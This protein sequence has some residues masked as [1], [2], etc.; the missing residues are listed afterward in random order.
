[1]LT[2]ELLL[3][4]KMN[5]MR[6][7]VALLV[8][9]LY[10]STLIVIFPGILV[11]FH[12]QAS[13]MSLFEQVVAIITVSIASTVVG[14]GLLKFL[15]IPFTMYVLGISLVSSTITIWNYSHIKFNLSFDRKDIFPLLLLVITGYVFVP[16]YF[17]QLV[18]SG[19]DM[20]THAYIAK[21]IEL[22]NTFPKTYEPIVPID[23]FGFEP[24]GLP[25]L[26]AAVSLFSSL[27]IYKSALLIS[28]L[29]YPLAGLVCFFLLK[30]QFSVITAFL[31]T[32]G[33]FFVDQ[34]FTSYLGWGAHPTI[35]SIV[36]IGASLYW[37]I[38]IFT[39]KKISYS[40]ILISAIL[41]T[42]AFL[43]HPT[44]VIA[45][46]YLIA[47][48]VLLYFIRSKSHI[49]YIKKLGLFCVL[50][51]AFSMPFITSI[52]PISDE[53]FGWLK[54]FQQKHKYITVDN[55]SPFSILPMH[56][57]KENGLSW[58]LLIVVGTFLT[59]KQ[60]RLTDNF[61]L[62]AVVIYPI[63]LLN[64]HIWLLPLSA[65]LYPD[66]VTTTMAWFFCYLVAT[67]IEFF[68]KTIHE[69]MILHHDRSIFSQKQKIA[70]LL[71]I[72]LIWIGP[73]FTIITNQYRNIDQLISSEVY[74]TQNDLNVM[75]WLKNN[76]QITDVIENNYS[77][78]GIWIPAVAERKITVNDAMPHSFDSLQKNQEKL[79][80]TYAFIGENKLFSEKIYLT[81]EWASELGY[82]LVFQSGN[83]R[84][85]KKSE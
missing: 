42:A 49:E 33:L 22:S 1:M 26:I 63:L 55:T 11:L 47:P 51:F 45:V 23:T 15:S 46:T 56:L 13:K 31:T 66:R 18:P 7:T 40:S 54:D 72:S 65:A 85:Y 3:V 24:F 61:I 41:V 81:P 62:G 34:D 4:I 32:L 2:K 74:V 64:S 14:F 35:A 38:D 12:Q 73:I 5:W 20:A 39:T 67:S 43:T 57:L 48:T 70:W 69:I 60:T 71:I 44:P 29:L 16:V 17:R 30:K 82:K 79:I 84:A 59:L 6:L 80:S 37:L 50:I 25:S 36:L 9:L 19:T 52:R 27:P 21:A 75:N 83:S 76:T 8:F 77:D 28:I 58:A 53:T 78:G 10:P 68:T